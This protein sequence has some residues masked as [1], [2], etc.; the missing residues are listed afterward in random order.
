M[1]ML[2]MFAVRD[3]PWSV[4]IPLSSSTASWEQVQAFFLSFLP[5]S[6][7]DHLSQPSINHTVHICGHARSYRWYHMRR[8]SIYRRELIDY[9]CEDKKNVL[10]G[11]ISSLKKFFTLSFRKPWSSLSQEMHLNIPLLRH[12]VWN[13][14][15]LN[16]V[17]DSHLF[18]SLWNIY[19]Q[20]LSAIKLNQMSV[21][22]SFL[23][24]G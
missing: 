12:G 19:H 10:R 2:P 20:W 7:L 15:I 4:P 3:F 6:A 11:N 18:T 24:R 17:L 23:L 8:T 22:I 16:Q 5:A 9:R 1:G 21:F 14:Q 13:H